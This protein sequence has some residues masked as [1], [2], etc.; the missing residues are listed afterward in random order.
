[1]QTLLQDPAKPLYANL[2]TK[3]S[4]QSILGSLITANAYFGAQPIVEALNQGADIVIT[5]RVA[6][7]SLTVAPCVYHYGWKWDDY[8]RL[9]GATVAGHL[10]ECGT[11]ATGGIS[12]NW[13]SL[14]DKVN[15]GF[16]FV[17]VEPDGSFV[18]TKPEN[19]GG[20]VSQEIVKEQLLYEIGDPSHYLSP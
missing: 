20:K 16:P 3:E 12:T 18:I 14:N 6:D 13:L 9:A 11:Q 17:E 7:P 19:T 1:M 10:I 15:I 2:E 4:I 5:G 8:D